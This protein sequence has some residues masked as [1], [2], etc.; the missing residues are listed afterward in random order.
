MAE[1]TTT[2]H[3]TANVAAVAM[4]P[5]VVKWRDGQGTERKG[6]IVYLSADR[7]HDFQQATHTTNLTVIIPPTSLSSS[8]SSSSFQVEFFEKEVFS[9]LREHHGVNARVWHRWSDQCSAQFKSKYTLHKLKVAA[10]ELG[11]PQ[12]AVIMWH[13]FEVV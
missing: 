1:E 8:S 10:E 5:V 12:D 2:S 7:R 11:L 13:H 4:Y 6:G 9:Y 3:F